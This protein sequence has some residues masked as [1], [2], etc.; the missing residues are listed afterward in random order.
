MIIIENQIKDAISKGARILTGG[1]RITPKDKNGNELKGYFFEPTVITDVNDSML[2]MK[3]ETF[4]PILPVV[5]FS[6]EEEVIQIV[7]SSEYGLSASVWTKDRKR[8]ERVVKKIRSGSV[9]VNEC[10]VHYGDAKAPCGG[11]KSSGFG[12]VHSEF[13]IYDMVNVKF[14]SYDFISPHRLWWF[15]Y[16]IGLLRTIKKSIDFL[17]SRSV[18]QKIKSAP[19]LLLNLYRRD[20]SRI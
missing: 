3:E 16:D 6:D 8:A 5:K 19:H 13:G 2:L 14:G 4:G 10:V 12:R 9:L 20:K 11:V 1:K 7:N 15:G 17:Y 18:I